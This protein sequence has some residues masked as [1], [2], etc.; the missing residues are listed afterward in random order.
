M[1][2]EGSDT[3]EGCAQTRHDVTQ[4]PVLHEILQKTWVVKP[5]AIPFRTLSRYLFGGISD[6]VCNRIAWPNPSLDLNPP[7]FS[8]LSSVVLLLLYCG[9]NRLGQDTSHSRKSPNRS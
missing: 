7:Y 2:N 1:T 4:R 5:S 3:S 9:V 8:P 6:L